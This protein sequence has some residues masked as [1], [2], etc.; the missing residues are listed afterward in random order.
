M[1]FEY[2][3]TVTLTPQLHLQGIQGLGFRDQGLKIRDKG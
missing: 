3:H 2:L 1:M